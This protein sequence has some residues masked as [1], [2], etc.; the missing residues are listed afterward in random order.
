MITIEIHSFYGHR[1]RVCEVTEDGYLDDDVED[2]ALGYLPPNYP[3]PAIQYDVGR[4][5]LGVEII[6]VLGDWSDMSNPNT[7]KSEWFHCYEY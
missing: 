7:N 5:P 3:V 4:G 6:R 1:M 2:Y